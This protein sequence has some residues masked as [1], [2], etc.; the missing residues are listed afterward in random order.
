[1]VLTDPDLWSR[2]RD[3]DLPHRVEWDAGASRPRRC[4]TFADNLRKLGDWTDESAARLV[5]EYRR[6]LYLKALDDELLTPPQ[7]IDDAWHLHMAPDLDFDDRFC[8]QIG[9]KITHQTGL[10]EEARSAAYERAL[11]RYVAEF[12]VEP[13]PDIW[14][15]LLLQKRNQIGGIVC[16][17][18]WLVVMIGVASSVV[19]D[20]PQWIIFGAGFALFVAG[21]IYGGSAQPAKIARCG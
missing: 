8:T 4:R 15:S 17:I 5:M 18:G 1:M 16:I 11:A 14:P 10:T 21:I 12:H 3:Y 20:G 19:F 7:C 6:F 2:I 13:P 9:R